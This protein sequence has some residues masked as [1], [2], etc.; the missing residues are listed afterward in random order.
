[1]SKP[2]IAITGI[3]R[4]GKNL[5]REFGKVSEIVAFCH[6]GNQENLA[7]L[8]KNYSQTPSKN[9]NS[10]LKDKT[11]KALV[12]A[13]PI[14][15]HYELTREA[16][17]AGKHVFV[18]KPITDNVK[19][20]QELVKLAMKKKRI[21]FVG[22]IFSY[23]PVLAKIKSI[24]HREPIKHAVFVWNKLGTFNEELIFNLLPHDIATALDLFGRPISIKTLENRGMVT[25]SDIIYARLNFKGNPPKFS[26][27]KL[28][29]ASRSCTI[30]IN[31]ISNLKNK[32]ITIATGKN[33]Y[34][35]ENDK[36]LKLNK[37]NSSFDLV[38]ESIKTPLEIECGE[39]IKCIS[40]NKKPPTDGGFGLEVVKIL[41]RI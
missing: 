11:I 25:D 27:G 39:F 9:Y 37:K 23:H 31:R 4:W 18:E 12:I 34:I 7:W 40:R 17:L 16:L 2:K 32:T 1:M 10:I 5:A 6:R 3:G 22:H 26:A 20:A 30:Y 24:A 33:V 29:R 28:R 19:Q 41:S 21:L 14:S 38:Y 8:K 13:T 36:L 15:T 35:W